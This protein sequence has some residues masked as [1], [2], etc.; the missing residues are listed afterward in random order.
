MS[1]FHKGVTEKEKVKDVVLMNAFL[2]AYWL[3]KVTD[4]AVLELLI[5]LIP[6]QTKWKHISFL[7]KTS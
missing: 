6:R 7:L 4:I 1:Q 2:A 3:A 5:T